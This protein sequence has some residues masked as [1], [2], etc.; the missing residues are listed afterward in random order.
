MDTAVGTEVV[1]AGR[2]ATDL[3]LEVATAAEVRQC[4]PNIEIIGGL[5]PRGVIVTSA[6]DDQR[7]VD[8]VSRFFA[9]NGGIVEDPVTGSAHTTLAAWWAPRLGLAFRAEQ[10]SARGGEMDGDLVGDRVPL[11][12]RA[13]TVARGM[14]LA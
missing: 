14:L 12:G 6:C 3:L 2:G 9:P 4:N 13:V 11:T 10:A 5:A 1:A 7:H 8:V